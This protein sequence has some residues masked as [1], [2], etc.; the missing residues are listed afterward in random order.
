[1]VGFL[2]VIRFQIDDFTGAKH[3]LQKA[4]ACRVRSVWQGD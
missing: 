4:E 1:M 3:V 2:I